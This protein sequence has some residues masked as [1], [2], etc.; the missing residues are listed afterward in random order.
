MELRI[1]KL[2]ETAVIPLLAY[3]T[4][5][6]FDLCTDEDFAVLPGEQAVVSTGIAVAIPVGYVG[7]V[8]DKSGIATKRLVKT[9]A[10]VID[11]GYRGE[12]KVALI[13]MGAET[14]VFKQGEKIAQMLIQPVAHPATLEVEDLDGTD[15]GE[16]GFGSTGK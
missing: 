3:D 15:R 14:Q 5:A 10:G 13:N 12:V 7:L 16:K 9:M 1:K 11:A 2:T 8:W 6:G 4:D